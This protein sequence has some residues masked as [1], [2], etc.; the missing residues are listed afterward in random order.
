M[1]ILS[2]KVEQRIRIGDEI[3]VVVL[4]I[5]GDHVRLGIQAPRQITV[6]RAELLKDVQEENRRAAAAASAPGAL[7]PVLQAIPNPGSPSLP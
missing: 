4:G 7:G 6:L 1:L 5:E 3:E 2:R